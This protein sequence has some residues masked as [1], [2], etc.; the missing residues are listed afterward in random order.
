MEQ[1]E[2]RFPDLSGAGLHILAMGLMLC[3]HL[4]AQLF[5]AEQ[6]L[7]WLGRLAFPIFAFLAAEGY[8]RTGNFRRYLLRLLVWAVISEVPF[9]LMYGGS[10][11][12][13]YHQ[14]VLWTLLL[15]LLAIRGLE[16]AKTLRP[17]PRILLYGGIPALGFLLGYGGMTDYYGV[18]VLTVVVFH[19]FH[20]RTWKDL[21]GQLACLYYLH[22]VLLG[23]FYVTVTVLGFELDLVQQGFALLALLPI[24]LYR[25]RQGLH[26]RGFRLVCY[27]FYPAHMLVL[28]LI[29]EAV[30]R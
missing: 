19:V 17:L 29:R 30:L 9:D 7:T 11:F 21:L 4:W 3:D 16:W 14:N 27:G 22:V 20:G 12:Y 6:W 28:Q 26:G 13:P 24:W 10:V 18:G 1:T 2:K 15:G 5:P 8:R 23:G 25:G